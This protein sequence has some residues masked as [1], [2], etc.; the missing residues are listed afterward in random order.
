MRRSTLAVNVIIAF[1][2]CIIFRPKYQ[3]GKGFAAGE[4]CVVKFKNNYSF[5]K[6]EQNEKDRIII[7]NLICNA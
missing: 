3:L 5:T 2:N 6:T 1:C 7:N 4:F